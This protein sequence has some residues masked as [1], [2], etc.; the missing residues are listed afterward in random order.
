M[1]READ[2][3]V[4]E[5][6]SCLEL[7]KALTSELEPRRLL[8]TILDK[9]SG[10]MPADN[11]S[12]L[13]LDEDGRRLRF[14]VTVGLDFALVKDLTLEAGRGVVG[15]A[16]AELKPQLVPDVAAS[17][18]FDPSVDRLSGFTTRAIICAPLVFAGK[19]LGAIEAVNPHRLDEA[20]LQLLT[21]IADFAA[22]AVENTRRYERIRDLSVRDDLTGL[23]NT[24]FLYQSLAELAGQASPLA[25]VF[26]DLDNFKRLVDAQ[27]HLLGS[28]ALA[29]VAATIRRCL[30]PPAYAVAYGGDE[31]VVVLPGGD[32]TS[33]LATAG[34]IK[35]RM[36]ATT[37]LAGQGKA[38]LLTASFGVAA[39]PGDAS[40]VKGLL[41]LADQAMFRVK[42]RSKNAVE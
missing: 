35:E 22:I 34:R 21:A 27:G 5:L 20:A 2:L 13:T 12:L 1:G 37:Y 39:C 32:K 33:A 7:G 36:A 19:A 17:E 23:Y 4:A 31:F 3:T 10:L 14:A 6:V 42:S 38:E 18:F 41:A 40:D 28:Q 24:R 29:E 16:V 26:L 30:T 25:L 11:W 15:R 8:Q 9:V